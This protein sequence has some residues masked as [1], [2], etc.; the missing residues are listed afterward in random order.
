M[1]PRPPLDL[2]GTWRAAEADD[3]LRRTFPDLDHHDDGWEQLAVPGHWRS[4]PAFADVDGPVLYRHRFETPRPALGTR[5]WLVFDGLFYQG[6]AWLD[7][8]YLGATEGYFVRH[9]FEVT[10]QLGASLEHVVAVEV[11]CPP[12]QDRTAKR[13]LL[14]AFGDGEGYDPDWNPGGI[15]RPVRI[16]HTGPV[17]ARS[18]RVL[19][20]DATEERARV[21][22][23]A[24][25]DSDTA[26][27]VVLR[28]TVGG[29]DSVEERPL[30]EGSNFVEWTVNVADPKLW[31]PHALG[32]QP[33]VD[34][35]VVVEV[36]GRTSHVLHR[37]IGL[38]SVSWHQWALSVNGERLFLKGA[39]LRPTR[40]AIAEATPG[41]LRRDIE[42][43]RE[44]GLDLVRLH[45]HVSRPELYEAADELGVLVWQD[46]PLR[47]GYSH[48]IR[49]Q[50]A[51]QA[52]AAVDLLGHHPSIALWC[53]HDEPVA[54]DVE[55]GTVPRGLSRGR[56]AARYTA[57][58]AVPTWNK[59]I[60][61][62]AVSRALRNADRSRPVLPHAGVLPGVI[63]GSSATHLWL[64]WHYGDERDLPELARTVPNLVRFVAAFGA[65]ALP[66]HD[67]LADPATW[68]DLD[69]DRLAQRHG[70]KRE[71][72]DAH[73]GDAE[74]RPPSTYEAWRDAGQHYQAEVVKHHV[75]TLRRLKYRPTG[76][77]SVHYLGDSA[78]AI[79]MA[80][81][82]HR[83]SP[84][85]AWDALV[86]A[87]RPV[88]VVADR[89]PPEVYPGEDLTIDIHVV[90]DR[91]QPMVG[92]T[93]TAR[94]RWGEES[95]GGQAE[96]SW[97]GDVE[98]DGVARVGTIEHMVHAVAGPLILELELVADGERASNRYESVISLS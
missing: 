41:E 2:S 14:G 51:R 80:L 72:L 25:L 77:F 4:N 78:P 12:Q 10:D 79:S 45:T 37:R 49:K 35:E 50:A 15:W 83:R 40:L 95:G 63:S 29:V 69:W 5:S 70:L 32:D 57:L 1:D 86:A 48:G 66:L 71:L 74:G 28:T 98:A 59:S 33:L 84:K 16:E 7:G 27:G 73:L 93:V 62:R 30:A 18:L 26:R 44:A 6:D 92:G 64:G 19:C 82:D 43:A 22:L 91:R 53:G 54:V 61:D 11:G 31:W 13:T 20:S 89:L 85:P 67:D 3:D 76:G 90:S 60:L 68:P 34:V 75:E 96:W 58:Q 24:E 94:F 47:R 36:G 65:Q 97:Q 55:P 88:L 56:L 46:L 23:R 21:D 9:T 17:R 42:L 87:C 81:L 39:N 52:E 8:A 38:R